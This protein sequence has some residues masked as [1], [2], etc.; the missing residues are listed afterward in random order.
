MGPE[1]LERPVEDSGMAGSHYDYIVVGGGVTGLAAAWE[2]A[3]ATPGTRRAPPKVAVIES[4]TRF[5]G[6]I[7]VGEIQGVQIDL[8]PDGFI[9]RGRA[10]TDLMAELGMSD[11]VAPVA[12]GAQILKRGVL[13]PLPGG[14]VGGV[15]SAVLPLLR[16]GLIGARSLPKLAKELAGLGPISPPNDVSLGQVVNARYG[17][18]VNTWVIEPLLGGIHASLSTEI[19]A[20]LTAPQLWNL[21]KSRHSVMRSLRRAQASQTSDS[22]GLRPMLAHTFQSQKKKSAAK[23]PPMF[24][25]PMEGPHAIINELVSALTRSGV[26]LIGGAR[27]DQVG[28]PVDLVYKTDNVPGAKASPHGPGIWQLSLQDGRRLTA[29]S[30]VLTTPA[31]ET[32]R[33]VSSRYPDAARILNTIKYSPVAVATF[34]FRGGGSRGDSPFP[35]TG[36]AKTNGSGFLVPAPEQML[37]TATTWLSRKW[38]RYQGQ[39]VDGQP[40]ELVRVSSGRMSDRRVNDLDDAELAKMLHAELCTVLSAAGHQSPETIPYSWHIQRWEKGLAQYE[41]GHGERVRL[42][43]KYLRSSYPPGS[44]DGIFVTGAAMGGVG[45]P[46]CIA[47]GRDAASKAIEFVE[48]NDRRG[49]P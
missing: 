13:H 33:L 18:E 3:K 15:P 12:R 45:I 24:L 22:R 26:D 14:L 11:P 29:T 5:G 31:F 20:E 2:L 9:S 1:G 27:V 23:L 40:L 32:A 41:P 8:G 42:V 43:G 28:K 10:A 39:T 30:I 34:A 49:N 16:S 46:A 48:A 21:S 44:T 35:V 17:H 36:L 7:G 47:S 19:S 37:M 25:S 4:S 6:K 38:E